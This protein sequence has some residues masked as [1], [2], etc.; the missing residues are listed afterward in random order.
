MMADADKNLQ[1]CR[2]FVFNYNQGHP[3][4]STLGVLDAIQKSYQSVNQANIH[5]FVQD[6]GKGKS[7]FALVAANYFK[8]LLDSPEVEGILDQIK[9]ASEHNQGIVQDLKTYK[10]RN[11]KHL[12]ICIN[13]GSS[14]LD[15]RK[16]F[17]RALRQ[18]LETEG[19]TDSL[20][21]QICQKPLEYLTQ[22]T[23]TQ[24]E[25]ANQYLENNGHKFGDLDSII[26]ELNQDNYRVVSTVKSISSELNDGFPID[27][28]TDLSVDRILEELITELC[29]GADAKY[30][31]ILILFDE[32]NNYLQAWSTDPYNSGGLTLQNIT[33]ACENYKSKI[34]L[35]CFTQIRPLKSVPNQSAEDYKKLASRLEISE[36]TYEP[37]SSLELVIKGL[38]D[39]QVNSNLWKQFFQTWNNT[40]LGDSRK[41]H[42]TRINIYR[43]R[44]WKLQDFQTNLTVGCFPLHPLNSYLLCNLD[45]TQGRTAIQYI[46]EN[47]KQ[48]INS[49]PVEKNGKLN[50]IPAISLIGFFEQLEFSR[51]YSEYQKAYDT[52]ASSATEAE[53]AVL[54]GL[55]LFYVSQNKLNKSESEKHDVILSELTGLSE[56][57]TKET[58]DILSQKKQVIYLNT[59]DNTYRF[60]SGSNLLEIS[61]EIEEEV[62]KKLNEISVNLAV[63]HCQEEVE[64]YFPS[65]KVE[66]IDFINK[67]KLLNDEWFFEYKFYNIPDFKRVLN[68][69]QAVENLEGKGIFAYVLAETLEELQELHHQI[70]DLLSQAKNK[71]QIAVA[72]PNNKPIRDIC[73]DLLAI[74]IITRKGRSEK[75]ESGTAY[76]Q[77]KKQLQEKIKREVKAIIG[78]STY[79]FLESDQFTTVQKQ[80][81]ENVVSHLLKQLYRFVPPL[82]KNDKMALNSSTGNTIIGYTAKRLLEDELNPTK[83][84]NQSYHTLVNQV[85]VNSW[86][87][88]T[89][90]SQKYS[91][92]IPTNENVREAWDK[93]DQ[94]TAL[95]DKKNTSININKIWQ[96]L[97]NSPFGYNEYTFTMLLT[98]WIVYHRSE[99]MLEGSFGIP[100]NSKEQVL[101]QKK[102]LKDWATTNVFDKPKDFVNKWI[103][104]PGKTPQLIRSQTVA[105]PEIPVTIDYNKA[106]KLIKEIDQFINS[107]DPDPAKVEEI[108]LKRKQLSDEVKK[109]NDWFKPVEEAEN[110]PDNVNLETLLKLYPSLQQQPQNINL[111]SPLKSDSIVVNPTKEQNQRQADAV[112]IINDKIQELIDQLSEKSESLKT[113][114]DYGYYQGELETAIEKIDQVSLPSHLKET[115]NYSL[116]VATRKLDEIK[117][118]TEIKDCLEKINLRY[119]SLSTNASQEDYIKALS[120]IAN[121]TNNLEIVKQESQYQTIIQDVES[122][123]ADLETTLEI[124]SE[125]LTGITKNEALKLS[126][127]VSE[128]KN[129]FT[130]IESAQK[131]KE[132]LEQLNPIILE[133]SNEE[134]TQAR[135]QQQDSEIMQQLRQNNP[136]FLN[137]INL[138]QQG[139]EKIT[140]LRSQLNYPE[141]FNT[142]IE[143]LINALN[144]QV[145]DFQ[146]Q[147]ENLKEQVDKI[148]TDQQLS[149]LQTD[150][151]KLD[152]IFKDS[153]DYSEYQQLLEVLKTK[154]ID[155]KNESQEE[156]IIDLFIQLPPER[157]QILYSKL[158]QHL[159]HNE[160]INE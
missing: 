146:Q 43:E 134:E 14:E 149:Q 54:K 126:Q 62:S 53:K 27:F 38:L 12:V 26:K 69:H 114:Q 2:G 152:L 109:I 84:P 145:L 138:C 78:S 23:D 46:K 25:R 97:S 79:Y 124:W 8:Q 4:S 51:H 39:Q 132:I 13:G 121:L 98:A 40:L 91:V 139:I 160:Q 6:Y 72:I 127:E 20:A 133:I 96:E 18:T 87:L 30:S 35:V 111:A 122:K 77:Y 42:E 15:L 7:H 32:L 28:E 9:I 73:K 108:K 52:I 31:G 95:E 48:F 85:F 24:K 22:L 100:K 105:C 135:K 1:L 75:E 67:N 99:V 136:K 119:N 153:D 59:G 82:A 90:T 17:L 16:I 93:I 76:E 113:E 115:L 33:D 64:T 89:N 63:N 37:V 80:N 68:S 81:P 41:A 65:Q 141:R 70:Y 61:Q 110:L 148:E 94:L 116:Q 151:A 157:Q 104:A 159:S 120:E 47:V 147:F 125:R 140:N 150:L 128:Q 118:Q 34:A 86:Q 74:D 106:E 156:K 101:I 92:Q 83:F 154:S 137:T 50:Y 107:A 21:P 56:K 144:N 129:R 112:I 29:S 36:S 44:G 10:R 49:Q 158:G 60:Y 71:K 123:Q 155:R 143:Q 102:P 55:F 45:F 57:E 131:V 130:Q 117:H 142:E 58:L 103:L 88:F 11:P 3:K 66:G 5:L 19:I